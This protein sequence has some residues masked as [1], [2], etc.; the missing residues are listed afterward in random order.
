[1]QLTEFSSYQLF[2]LPLCL[3]STAEPLFGQDY[4]KFNPQDYLHTYYSADTVG[5]HPIQLLT[6]KTLHDFYQSYE[7]TE[8][9]L[10]I[11]DVGSGPVI[12]QTISAAPYATEIVLSEYAEA[13]R[14]AL[15][16]WLNNDPNA[17]DWTHIIKHIVVNLEG[18][19]EEE[20]PIRAELVRK[21]VKAV[22]HCDVNQDPPIPSQYVGQYDIVTAFLCLTAACATREDYV[23]ALVRLH[24]LLKSGGKIVLYTT[25]R[26][27]QVTPTPTSYT[28]GSQEFFEL[29]LSRDL[30]SKSLKEAGFCDIK[31]TVLPRP[32]FGPDEP[33]PDIVGFNFIT[34]SKMN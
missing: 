2:S 21:V 11:L 12:A 19:S 6:L 20:V 18:K 16:Q 28:V 14:A 26:K 29:R 7:S 27:E 17:F 9:K 23:A 30:I 34:A 8:A 13:N 25:D 33:N 3:R 32:N 10:K 15:L 31:V 24:A 4:D 5:L 1:M 22:V